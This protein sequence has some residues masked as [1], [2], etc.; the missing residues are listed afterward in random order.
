MTSYGLIDLDHHK[1][2]LGWVATMAVQEPMMTYI[3]RYHSWVSGLDSVQNIYA[4]IQ[5][6]RCSHS[7]AMVT[8]KQEYQEVVTYHSQL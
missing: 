6:C 7:D 4:S 8:A 3:G 5:H 2:M 1:V